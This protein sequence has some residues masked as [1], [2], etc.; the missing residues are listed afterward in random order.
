[1]N[2]MRESRQKPLVERAVLGLENGKRARI[3]GGSRLLVVFLV[4]ASLIGSAL[5]KQNRSS[6]DR[7]S[8]VLLACL[9]QRR[10]VSVNSFVVRTFAMKLFGFGDKFLQRT[11]IVGFFFAFVIGGEFAFVDLP[12]AF[13]RGARAL[14]LLPRHAVTRFGGRG[15]RNRSA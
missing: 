8:A 11:V 7:A 6:L 13:G 9:L 14:E 1:R 15:R 5:G 4:V 3:A 10:F 12:C 2:Q